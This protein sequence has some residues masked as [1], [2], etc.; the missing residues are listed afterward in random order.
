[1]E[2]DP[3]KVAA[4]RMSNKILHCFGRLLREETHMYVAQ[5]RVYRRRVGKW[6]RPRLLRYRS[7]SNILLFSS[8][9]LVEY[10]ALTGFVVPKT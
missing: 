3:L 7:S 1:M 6:R 10:V 4:S 5:S 8:G 9:P 2:N